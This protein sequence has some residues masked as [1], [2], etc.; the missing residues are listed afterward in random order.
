M[1][2]FAR[3]G[4][5]PGD[6]RAPR[7]RPMR[8][9]PDFWP[10]PAPRPDFP[11]LCEALVARR[12]V[13]FLLS[14]GRSRLERSQSPSHPDP[15]TP[16]LLLLGAFFAGFL[17]CRDGR[18]QA[19]WGRVKTRLFFARCL[20]CRCPSLPPWFGVAGGAFWGADAPVFSFPCASWPGAMSGKK[21][22][23]RMAVWPYVRSNM[24]F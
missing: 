11:L 4:G 8:A 19:V 9:A 13:D 1:G 5:G 3:L 22:R 17:R 6:F 10:L 20:L 15:K 2:W 16:C 24:S 21:G 14:F 18:S 23:L 12:G 7:T